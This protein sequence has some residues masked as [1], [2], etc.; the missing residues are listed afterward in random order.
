M[1]SAADYVD[2][3]YDNSSSS[4]TSCN[5]FY[6]RTIPY[7]HIANSS[8]PFDDVLCKEGPTAAVAFDTGLLDTHEHLGI[9]S[10]PSRRLQYRRRTTC[11]PLTTPD[12]LCAREN[13]FVEGANTTDTFVRCYYGPTNIANY[14]VSYSLHQF[15]LGSTGYQ[16]ESHVAYAGTDPSTWDPIPA[17]NRTDADVSLYLIMQNN[18]VYL[19][20]VDDPLF[21]A[22]Q[23]TN[24]T[25]GTGANLQT[26]KQY[27]RDTWIDTLGCIDQHQVCNPNPHN[28]SSP[29]CTPLTSVNGLTDALVQRSA[30]REDSYLAMDSDQF[31]IATLLI[32]TIGY[33]EM[34]D[35]VGAR[36]ASALKANQILVGLASPGLPINQ[37]VIEVETWFRATLAAVQGLIV[38]YAAGPT[39]SNGIITPPTLAT[40]QALCDQMLVRATPDGSFQ[41]FSVL[42]LAIVLAIS[43]LV[44]FLA[45][46]LRPVVDFISAR[47][48]NNDWRRRTWRLEDKLQLH[49]LAYE[50]AGWTTKEVWYKRDEDAVPVAMDEVLFPDVNHVNEQ[51]G[52]GRKGHSSPHLYGGSVSGSPRTA[53][54]YE[55]IDQKGAA[56]GVRHT[57]IV[58]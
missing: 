47:R 44:I 12:T 3:C 14:T 25:F 48:H 8:C 55:L 53:S 51:H 43:G 34:N 46:A 29:L 32:G 58:E 6:S 20:P 39:V 26:I 7:N 40:D 52:A 49:R 42:G 24:T 28:Q 57:G 50:G 38:Q 9:N 54:G 33:W 23:P 19:D 35:V 30:E 4:A 13:A 11:S 41:N 10:R 16:L 45:L 27:T 17:L 31:S 56:V 18:I 15:Y 5:K 37:W 36:G 1:L 22:H 2:N 21:A